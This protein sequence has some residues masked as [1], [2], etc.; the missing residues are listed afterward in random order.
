MKINIKI[1]TPSY[2]EMF[3]TEHEK[4]R[5]L[6]TEEI[7]LRDIWALRKNENKTLVLLK[8]ISNMDATFLQYV[9]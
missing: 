5:I 2:H 1:F 8:I 4:P 7:S 6:S 3:L 9:P